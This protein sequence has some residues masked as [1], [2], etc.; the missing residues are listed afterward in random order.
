MAAAPKLTMVSELVAITFWAGLFVQSQSE[1]K[2]TCEVRVKARWRTL[3]SRRQAR[4]YRTSN[5]QTFWR[6][7]LFLDAAC[8]FLEP[9]GQESA[10]TNRGRE[11]SGLP[12]CEG[13]ACKFLEDMFHESPSS[14]D[15]SPLP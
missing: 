6:T 10:A 13:V 12:K 2:W 15:R 11:T 4:A 9:S 8:K 3:T 5:P 14:Q 1:I 7:V